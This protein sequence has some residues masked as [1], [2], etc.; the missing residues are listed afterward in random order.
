MKP[1]FTNSGVQIQTFEE[2]FEDLSQGYRDIYGQDI[3]LSQESPDGQRVGIEARARLDLQS[4][5]LALANSFDPD[6]ADGQG[7]NKISKLAGIFPRP[8]TRSQWDL[9]VTTDRPLMLNSGYTIED[10]LGQEWIVP[11]EVELITGHNTVTFRAAVTG[12]VTG[13]TGAEFEEVTFVRGVTGLR[14]DVDAVPGREEETVEE[15]RRRRASSLENPAYS[16]VGALFAKLA[17]LP[18]VTD[19]AVYENDQ[20]TDDPVT[21]IEANTVWAIVENGT[22]D[23]IVETLVKQRTSGAR[24]KGNVEGTFTETLIR[25]NGAEFFMVHVMRFDRP[26]YVDISVRLTVT[27]KDTDEPVDLEL[28]K[29]QLASRELVIGESLQAGELYENTYGVGNDYIVTDIEISDDGG[30]T[31]TEGKLEPALDEKYQIET[32]NIDITEVIP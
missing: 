30:M 10:E 29:Q 22:V 4:F 27:R 13:T 19:L 8:G 21:G 9:V 2:I 18:R 16:T 25:P 11:E 17:N 28:I 20:P 32:A 14:A 24:T 3:N 26:T 23:N 6:F 7:L 31:W 12:E 1:E 5:A 15:F